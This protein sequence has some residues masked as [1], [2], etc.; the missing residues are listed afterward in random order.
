MQRPSTTLTHLK[1]FLVTLTV[2]FTAISSSL[3]GA[4]TNTLV[5]DGS[6]SESSLVTGKHSADSIRYW[7]CDVSDVLNSGTGNKQI[8]LRLWSDHNGFIGESRMLWNLSE[9]RLQ[10]QT[11]QGQVS[12]HSFEFSSLNEENDTFIATS[13]E[14]EFLECELKG[15]SM[16]SDANEM[17]FDDSNILETFLHN[18]SAVTWNCNGQ[19][20]G[21]NDYSVVEF[22]QQGSGFASGQS[23]TWYFDPDSTLFLTTASS[24]KVV[25]DF[26]IVSQSSE[27]RA[28]NGTVQGQNIDC[29]TTL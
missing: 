22:D 29:S 23:L 19:F 3:V 15:P 11:A 12:L 13:S 18:S 6:A 25:E 10:V 14:G 24:L 21:Q 1:S 2:S 17:V 5:N 7:Q 28:F 26:H 9:E 4:N 20:D 27:Y 8:P 16:T